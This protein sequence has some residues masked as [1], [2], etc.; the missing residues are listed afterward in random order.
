MDTNVMIQPKQMPTMKCSKCSTALQFKGNGLFRCPACEQVFFASKERRRVKKEEAVEKKSKVNVLAV[1]ISALLITYMITM[2]IALFW[3]MM[4][5]LKTNSEYEFYT[6]NDV[7]VS[8]KLWLPKEGISLINYKTAYQYFYVKVEMTN[9]T[10]QF[11]IFQQFLNSIL[12]SFGCATAVTV[13][14]LVMGYA[15]ARFKYKFSGYIYAFVLV[16]MALPI[17]GSMPSEI[18][19]ADKLNILDTFPGMW[20]MKANFLNTYFLIFFAQFKM[21]P[22][23]YTEAAKIDGASPLSVMVKIIVPL[24]SATTSTVFVLAFIGYWNDFQIPM[25]YLRSHPVAAYGMYTFQNTAIPQIANTPTR[26]AGIF[27]MALPI[28]IFYAIFNKKLNVNLS[29]GGIKG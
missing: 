23:D 8:N 27:L 13:V 7:I 2:G 26:L 14:S 11:N 24:A 19:V 15:T 17:V 21:I 10:L 4:T 12:Y 5:T 25:V 3:T 20:I 22:K 6:V 29:V 16:T 28:V 1:V 9:Y 18:A